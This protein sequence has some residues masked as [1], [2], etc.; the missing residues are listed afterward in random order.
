[1]G[2]QHLGPLVYSRRGGGPVT[3]DVPKD[4]TMEEVLDQASEFWSFVVVLV[5]SLFF[6]F[7]VEATKLSLGCIESTLEFNEKQ[8]AK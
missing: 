3:H 5:C 7:L 8:S 6:F 2:W 1:M 4:A